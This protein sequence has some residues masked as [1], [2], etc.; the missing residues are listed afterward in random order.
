VGNISRT[1]CT[2]VVVSSH[3]KLTNT[4]CR[5]YVL[6]SLSITLWFE[7]AHHFSVQANVV[8]YRI[9]AVAELYLCL[10]SDGMV[11]CSPSGS[12]SHNMAMLA[13]F[14]QKEWRMH[15]SL[16]CEEWRG[17][18]SAIGWLNN[19]TGRRRRHVPLVPYHCSLQRTSSVSRH[20]FTCF[21]SYH[22]SLHFHA[23]AL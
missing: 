7:G 4:N 5:T 10:Y 22:A 2:L 6:K 3:F 20:W 8:T 13:G 15:H 16:L 12:V 21:V 9:R 18:E 23:I 1:M 17:Y 11:L 19:A 14:P